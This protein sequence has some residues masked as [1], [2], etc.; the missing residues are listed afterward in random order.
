MSRTV[1]PSSFAAA[2][3]ALLRDERCW[4]MRAY[5][6]GTPINTDGASLPSSRAQ[7]LAGSNFRSHCTAAP[8]ACAQAATLTTPCRWCIG[9][10]WS[11][12][13][14]LDHAHASRSVAVMSPRDACVCSTPLGRDVVPLVNRI[15]EPSLADGTAAH[16]GSNRLAASRRAAGCLAERSP[17]GAAESCTTTRGR[18]PAG[19]APSAADAKRAYSACCGEE[20]GGSTRAEHRAAPIE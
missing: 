14:S 12:V 20:V 3:S 10:V 16:S 13:S 11:T 15:S 1:L 19:S 9:S 6:V 5:M 2:L 7:T 8:D 4:S 17:V 18:A